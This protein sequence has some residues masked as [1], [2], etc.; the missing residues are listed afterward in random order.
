MEG[1]FDT[2]LGRFFAFVLKNDIQVLPT[3]DE[4]IRIDVE[5]LN[6]ISSILDRRQQPVWIARPNVVNVNLVNRDLIAS[7]VGRVEIIHTHGRIFKVV[8]EFNVLR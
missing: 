6:C 7:G 4:L 8:R 5:Y 2:F 3:I 1:L